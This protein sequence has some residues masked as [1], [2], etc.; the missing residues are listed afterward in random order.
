MSYP[1]QG[2]IRTDA[3]MPTA[4]HERSPVRAAGTIAAD[5]ED[6]EAARDRLPVDCEIR[7][8]FDIAIQPLREHVDALRQRFNAAP[9]GG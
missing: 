3:D 5:I 9:V 6:L 1:T 2:D 4:R 7:A 8:L